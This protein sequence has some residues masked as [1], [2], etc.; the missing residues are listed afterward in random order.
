[1]C[2]GLRGCRAQSWMNFRPGRHLSSARKRVVVLVIVGGV[3]W[4]GFSFGLG[5]AK[6]A[7][8]HPSPAQPE[9]VYIL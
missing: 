9:A 5:A 1:M 2:S 8:P 4:P 6:D 3:G 7:G